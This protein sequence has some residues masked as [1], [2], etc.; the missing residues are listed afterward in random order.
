MNT[1]AN[2]VVTSASDARAINALI[3]H[4][5]L[6]D[7]AVTKIKSAQRVLGVGFCDAA[8]RLGFGTQED[9]DFIRRKQMTATHRQLAVP[10]NRL[11][12]VEDPYSEHSEAV[13]AL[14]TELL[15][16]RSA[17]DMADFV[18]VL[19]PTSGEG[20]SSLAAELAILFAQLCKPTLLV[21]ANLRNPAQHTLFGIENRLGLSDALSGEM[22]PS[23]HAVQGLP[24]LSLLTAGSPH[25][26][27]LELLSDGRLER[28]V[29]EWQ[30]S[31]VFVVV[32]TPPVDRYSD[33]LAV[34]RLTGRVLIVNR[35][36]H[37]RHEQTKS[38]LRKLSATQSQIL[39]AVIT[40]F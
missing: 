24:H 13:R 33:G 7:L 18:T 39:G 23:I 8:L 11:N 31:F 26:S 5:G 16:R 3:Q 9:I 19:S 35:A 40:R 22:I 25:N 20:C 12:L 36:Q 14:R 27:P 1:A 29:E 21:D 28:M 15:L 6:S 10:S 37:T 34:A 30:Q 17:V 2:D 4:L 38:L 32:D